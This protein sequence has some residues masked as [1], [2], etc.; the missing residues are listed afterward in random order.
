M[1]QTYLKIN[2]FNHYGFLIVILF[3]VSEL[4]ARI[5]EASRKRTDAKVGTE[6]YI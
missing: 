3:T 5:K 6:I 4:S 1:E 2:K